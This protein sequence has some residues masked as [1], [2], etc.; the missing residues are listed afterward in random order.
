MELLLDDKTG[1]L[2]WTLERN[3]GWVLHGLVGVGESRELAIPL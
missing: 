3:L 2:E 1:R